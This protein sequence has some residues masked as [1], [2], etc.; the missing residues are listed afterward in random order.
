MK[1]TIAWLS[2]FN[3]IR[4][5]FGKIFL[6]FWLS[7]CA[8]IIVVFLLARFLAPPVDISEPTQADLERVEGPIRM[9]GLA[10]QRETPLP[11]AL[12]RVASR[13]RFQLL[14]VE[15]ETDALIL[16]FPSPIL[17]PKNPLVE[18]AEAEQPFHI[19][20]PNMEFIGPFKFSLSQ[21]KKNGLM[22][23][24]EQ[25]SHA[26]FV[27]RLLKREE[28]EFQ[29]VGIALFAILCVGTLLC[30]LLAKRL[31]APIKQ[32]QQISKQY[33]DGQLDVRTQL[34]QT[35]QD[36]IG[37]LARDFE[38]MADK[39]GASMQ[40]QQALLANVSHE[41][42]TPLTRLQLAAAMLMESKQELVSHGA[43]Y[44]QRIEQEVI[45]M[46]RLIAQILKLT[47]FQNINAGL[48]ERKQAFS[49]LPCHDI[50]S[51][52]IK[53]LQFEAH[54]ND[55]ELSVNAMPEVFIE[56][57]QE[58]LVSMLENVARNAIRFANSKVEIDFRVLDHDASQ[59]QGLTIRISDDGRGV[60]QSDLPRLFDPFYQAAS[61]QNSSQNPSQNSVQNSSQSEQKPGKQIQSENHGLGLAIV[62]AAVELHNGKVEASKATLGGLCICITL[63]CKQK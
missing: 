26:L 32:L 15:L 12:R 37:Q 22:L 17:P 50:F 4:S 43:Q 51:Q 39:I 34:A 23:S 58:A 33:A 55:I 13:G 3:P 24:D 59:S 38:L 7:V 40:H 46:D 1:K 49:L 11:R 42:R 10:L 63:P 29:A 28:R 2:R 31:T 53:D 60:A 27:G 6:W 20:A 35:R 41:L 5:I 52:S 36:E 54:A 19:K 14:V 62:K 18:L 48:S 61:S 44:L 30:F 21:A 57:D 9:L 45:T 47:R 56:A 16:G 8:L 25:A